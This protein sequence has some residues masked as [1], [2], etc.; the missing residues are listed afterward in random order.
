MST[1]PEDEQTEAEATPDP[2]PR[3][4]WLL[5]E[6]RRTAISSVA[7][8]PLAV[9]VVALLV[10]RSEPLREALAGDSTTSG[11][12][13]IVV[14]WT[15]VAI[16]HTALTWLTY[17]GLSDEEFRRAVVADPGWQKRHEGGRN[18]LIRLVFGFGP[19]SWSVGIATL[20][21]VVVVAMVAASWLNVAVTYAV[22][23]ARIDRDRDALQFPGECADGFLDYL[24]VALGI[25][26]TAGVTG[27]EVTTREMRRLVLGHSVL[28]FV[29]NTAIIGMVISLL[30]GL[31]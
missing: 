6:Y 9:G 11:L 14:A 3:S 28:A 29:F 26:T 20:A 1:A 19:S 5:S 10:A 8:A 18:R 2:L 24:F 15:V 16:V 31:A 27:V 22:H 17:R 4:L 30:L 7:A 12:F 25:Q 23:Y 21:L 13:G